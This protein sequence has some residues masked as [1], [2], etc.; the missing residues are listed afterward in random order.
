MNLLILGGTRFV[1]LHM[2]QA[3]LDRGWRVSLYHRG[4]TNPDALPN[5]WHLTGDRNDGYPRGQWDAA[6][7][8]SGYIP[9]HAGEAAEAVKAYCYMF[10]STVSVYE[11]TAGKSGPNEESPRVAPPEPPTE[12]ITGETYGG[13]KT[14]CED[15][16]LQHRP[17]A[18][19]LRPGLV[20]GPHDYTNRFDKWARAFRDGGDVS[21]PP[22]LA[23]PLQLIHARDLAEFA[24]DLLSSGREGAYNGVGPE[25]TLGDMFR[26]LAA[27]YPGSRAVPM[28]GTTGPF[29]LAE[30]GSHD[31]LLRAN[32]T[33]SRFAGLQARPV[34]TVAH[35]S[36]QWI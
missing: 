3:A 18:S 2:A 13:L 17:D 7:D 12:E 22:R 32:D 6:I 25:S 5:A 14:A 35:E 16:V 4:Q 33:K 24:L 15:V 23:Q 21:V 31:G 36:S 27:T 29:V 11:Q 9:R 26:A 1:G 28:P 8:V 30:D 10:V 20:V 19:I 34:E